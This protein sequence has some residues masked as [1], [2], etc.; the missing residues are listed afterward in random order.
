MLPAVELADI[1]GQ[2]QFNFQHAA[3][4]KEDSKKWLDFAFRHDF[5]RNGPSIY[6]I[7]RTTLDGWKR[8]KNDADA[9]VQARFAWESRSLGSGYAAA[10]WAM[11]RH[12]RGTNAAQAAKVGALRQEVVA[13]FGWSSR[14]I[15]A[16]LGPVLR[17]SSRREERRLAAGHTYEP[18]PIVERRNWGAGAAEERRAPALITLATQED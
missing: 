7:C 8:Y 11:E 6:R 12:L 15:S 2:H 1:H 17:W 5:E 9:R 18:D 4:S 3:I 16:A 14:M 10:L 13:E